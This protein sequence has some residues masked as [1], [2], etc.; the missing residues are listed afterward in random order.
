V[1]TTGKTSEESARPGADGHL[2][3]V[4]RDRSVERGLAQ[5]GGECDGE[6]GLKDAEDGGG[7]RRAGDDE[8]RSVG[9]GRR[10][11][12]AGLEDDGHGG[13][14]AGEAGQRRP[15][16]MQQE[17]VDGA[18]ADGGVRRLCVTVCVTVCVRLC[19]RLCVCGC[20]GR[21]RPPLADDLQ[22]VVAA[23]AAAGARR[24]RGERALGRVGQ[25]DDGRPHAGSAVRLEDS[26][27]ESLDGRPTDRRSD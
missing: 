16:R 17:R 26:L 15:R 11:R 4:G 24:R 8:H 19:V 10:R 12:A 9:S 1:N 2:D 7:A 13:L 14:G 27:G 21:R 22:V 18:D 5:E 3:A 25:I 23:A 20:A 6:T